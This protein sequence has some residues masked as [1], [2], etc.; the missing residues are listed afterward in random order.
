MQPLMALILCSV[1]LFCLT[2]RPLSA[3]P[4]VQLLQT[5]KQQAIDYKSDAVLIV[6]GDTT[7]LS[8]TST[9][10][11]QPIELMSAYKSIVALAIG[12]LLFNGQLAA[13]DE[14]VHRFYPEWRQGDKAKITVRHLLN[15]TSGL[16]NVKNAGEEIYPSPDVIQLALAADLSEVPGTVTSYNNK[17]VNLLAGVIEKASGVR[18]DRFIINELFVPLAIEQ[19]QFYFDES[20]NPHAMAGLQ[21]TASDAAKFGL[22]VARFGQ[23]QDKRLI[24]NSYIEDMLAQS[25]PAEPHLGLLWWRHEYLDQSGEPKWLYFAD[26]Y[27]G[28]YIVVVPDLELVGVRQIKRR[29]DQINAGNNFREFKELIAQLALAIS[30]A[31]K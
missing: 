21:L 17:A 28:Q 27:L 25:Q 1:L 12:R 14:P 4:A 23:W 29:E 22:L 5:I 8:Y 15:H 20:G 3:E 9:D 6:Q 31:E 11:E 13:L 30:S 2:I 18:M 10:T 24:S 26:G 19:Y 16:Q 7:L